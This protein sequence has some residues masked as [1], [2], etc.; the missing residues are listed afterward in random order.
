[1]TNT[2]QQSQLKQ[3]H[4][5]AQFLSSL[6]SRLNVDDATIANLEKRIGGKLKILGMP[7]VLSTRALRRIMS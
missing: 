3:D 7:R 1:M 4:G 2:T 5:H 6:R